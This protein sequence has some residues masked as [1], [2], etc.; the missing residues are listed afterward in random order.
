MFPFVEEYIGCSTVYRK[1]ALI[2]TVNRWYSAFV[3]NV[4]VDMRQ[5]A[6]GGRLWI[7]WREGWG[8]QR[9]GCT[10]VWQGLQRYSVYFKVPP[11]WS[12]GVRATKLLDRYMLWTATHMSIQMCASSRRIEEFSN[13]NDRNVERNKRYGEKEREGA[14]IFK[15]RD[16]GELRCSNKRKHGSKE[17]GYILYLM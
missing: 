7:A 4:T 1:E 6:C 13:K 10:E 11:S 5:R 9:N 16:D 15:K 12:R 17:V 14:P 8:A 3:V 2:T